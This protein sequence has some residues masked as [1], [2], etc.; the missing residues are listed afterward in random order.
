MGM[1][2]SNPEPMGNPESN[3]ASVRER[4]DAIVNAIHA[5][6]L[7]LAPNDPNMEALPAEE[8]K[9]YCHAVANWW[10]SARFGCGTM[11]RG[12]NANWDVEGKARSPNTKNKMKR[13]TKRPAPH[14]LEM[15]TPVGRGGGGGAPP[16]VGA[17][18]AAAAAVAG[19]PTA[20]STARLAAQQAAAADPAAAAVADGGGGD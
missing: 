8:K 10:S 1:A 15:D 20:A 16:L 9:R 14:Q 12:V 18:A 4:Y 2:K 17:A 13:G 6:K 19:M 11:Y 5:V 3:K 7:G